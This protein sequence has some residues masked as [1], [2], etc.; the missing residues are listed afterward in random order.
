M[1]DYWS[2]QDWTNLLIGEGYAN[3]SEWL[4]QEF[5]YLTPILSSF[6]RGQINN[7]FAAIGISTGIIGLLLYLLFVKS[8]FSRRYIFIPMSFIA[9]WIVM[10]FASG[11]LIGVLA[12]VPILIAAIVFR[13]SQ[14]QHV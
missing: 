6:A 7:I 12:W 3:Y 13:G 14:V 5:G 9:V 8:I 11:M 1:I 4:R 2:S 10:H